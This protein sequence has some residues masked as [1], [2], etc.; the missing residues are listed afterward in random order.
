[1]TSGLEDGLDKTEASEASAAL[2]AWLFNETTIEEPRHVQ[3]SRH[4][5]GDRRDR[6]SP[7]CRGGASRTGVNGHAIKLRRCFI[8]WPFRGDSPETGATAPKQGRQPKKRAKRAGD[9]G[10]AEW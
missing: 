3:A 7:A 9:T 4:E 8:A 10:M 6:A 5:T 1:M 2:V